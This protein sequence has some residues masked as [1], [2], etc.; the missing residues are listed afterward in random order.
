M[1]SHLTLPKP[2]TASPKQVADK[3]FVSVNKKKNVVYVLSI[4]KWIM[5]IIKNIPEAIFKKLKL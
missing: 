2:L 4:W 5:M 3:I 1:T